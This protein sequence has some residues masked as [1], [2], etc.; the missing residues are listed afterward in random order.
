MQGFPQR[1]RVA[2][3]RALRELAVIRFE[4]LPRR[5]LMC[6]MR[7]CGGRLIGSADVCG[8]LP[9]LSARISRAES[10]L[11]RE[12]SKR[13]RRGRGDRGEVFAHKN[14]RPKRPLPPFPSART[15]DLP[16]RFTP[17]L[18]LYVRSPAGYLDPMDIRSNKIDAGILW[19][20]LTAMVLIGGETIVVTAQREASSSTSTAAAPNNDA[21]S[22]GAA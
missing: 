2:E 13:N 7:R 5:L 21:D 4:L 12:N 15:R 9:P 14:L 11:T 1:R 17:P 19:R 16:C 6:A 10:R 8:A 20:S 3:T 22:A 18:P